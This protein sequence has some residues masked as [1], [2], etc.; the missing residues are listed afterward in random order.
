VLGVP[1]P[2]LYADDDTLA[3]WILDYTRVSTAT[4]K[5]IIAAPQFIRIGHRVARTGAHLGIGGAMARVA[6]SA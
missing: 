2:D 6:G 1:T 5:S 3:A 4:R